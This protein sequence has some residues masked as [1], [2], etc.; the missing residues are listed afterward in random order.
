LDFCWGTID[1]ISE[2]KIRENWSFLGIEF[3]FD[4]IVHL[5]SEKIRR[6]EIWGELNTLKVHIESACKTAGG[7]RFRESWDSFENH[8]AIG[9]KRD[10][11]T[12]DEYTLTDNSFFYF[13]SYLRDRVMHGFELTHN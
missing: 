9:K 13:F 4:L 2:E 5:A 11:E 12:I 10:D 7:E 6:E 8:M 1:F 3:C